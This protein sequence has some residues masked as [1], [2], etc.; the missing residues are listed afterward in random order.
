[1]G[2]RGGEFVATDEPA[3]M[4]KPFLDAIVME[5]SQSEGG[6]SNSA[7]TDESDGRE[8]FCEADDLLDQLVASKEGPWWLWWRFSGY[9]RWK[10]QILDPLLVKIADLVRV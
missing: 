4:A 2:E 10:Y 7:G 3:V 1:M 6:L 8:V 5:D 9:A